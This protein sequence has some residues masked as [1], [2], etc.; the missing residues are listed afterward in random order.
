[1]KVNMKKDLISVIVPVYNVESYIKRCIDSIINQSYNNLEIILVDDGST[2]NS[3]NICDSY[4]KIDARI[5]VIH[6]KNGG[7]SSARNA[8]IEI[9]NGDYIAFVDSDDFIDKEMYEDLHKNAKESGCKIVTCS[10]K[11]VY[12]NDKI[13]NKH[14]KLY[15]KKY[16][17]FE[18]IK[19]MNTY[20]NFDMSACTKLFQKELFNE[21]RFPIGKLS[22]DYY[23]MYLL[24]EKAGS[25]YFIS[26]DY[27]NYFQRVN[28]ITK[29]K[30]INMDFMYA[31][32]EQMIYLEG[33]YPKQLKS[34]VRSAFISSNLTV[35]DYY[36]K[37]NMKCP[38]KLLLEMK[39]NIKDNYKYL[40]KAKMYGIKKKIQFILFKYS[41]PLY[42][43]VFYIYNC[44]KYKL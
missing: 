6:K 44:K 5:K 11:Y 19:E 43:V 34:I 17:F 23:I 33:K 35:Y 39:K 22:E 41:V 12:D 1:M 7:L 38:K 2:D 16:D 28:S 31:S 13:V 30:N 9:S 37:K 32:Y 42:N 3:G 14:K 20:E 15:K 18:A 21:I 40:D 24:F 8:G 36:L 10:Y 29:S 26:N 4:K 25:V 27:Y